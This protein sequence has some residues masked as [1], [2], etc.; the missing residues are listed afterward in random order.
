MTKT[1]VTLK[2]SPYNSSKYFNKYLILWSVSRSAIDSVKVYISGSNLNAKDRSVEA[3]NLS[4]TISLSSFLI[5]EG[6]EKAYMPVWKEPH[7]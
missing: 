2:K 4:H 6:I 5:E 3:I 7:S 1:L